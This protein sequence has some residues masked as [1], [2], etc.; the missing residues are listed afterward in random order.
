MRCHRD[1]YEEAMERQELARGSRKQ[2]KPATTEPV[3][4]TEVIPQSLNL[5]GEPDEPVTTR[6]RPRPATTAGHD[7]FVKH[8]CACYATKYGREYIFRGGRDG[9]T[10]KALITSIKLDKLKLA[11][12]RYLANND[13]FYAGHDLGRFASDINRFLDGGPSKEGGREIPSI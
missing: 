12:S 8:F 2:M 4:Q 5:L 13:P 9:K 3:N 10:V 6:K 11:A 7:S 1:C